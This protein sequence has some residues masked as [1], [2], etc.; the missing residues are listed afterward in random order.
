MCIRVCYR[1]AATAS[2][3]GPVAGGGGATASPDGADGTG[4]RLPAEQPEG[5]AAQSDTAVR[6]LPGTG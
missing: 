6:W 4:Q 2:I 1:G 3:T 5:G